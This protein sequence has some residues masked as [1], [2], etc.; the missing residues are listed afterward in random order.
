MILLEDMTKREEQDRRTVSPSTE[1]VVRGRVLDFKCKCKHYPCKVLETTE[2]C[3]T[4]NV[5]PLYCNR[6]VRLEGTVTLS[7]SRS[8][9]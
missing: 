1:S 4:N 3:L 2:K 5:R 8:M 6:K 9:S 7:T